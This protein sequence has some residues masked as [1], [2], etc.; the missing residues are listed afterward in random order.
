MTLVTSGRHGSPSSASA[1]LQSSLESRLLPRLDTAGSTLFVETWK[2]KA[3]PLRRRYWEHT[4]SARRTSGSACTSVP[5]PD[6]RSGRGGL[7][8]DPSD[9]SDP[10]R[11][12][13]RGNSMPLESMVL[14]SSVPTP[15]AGPQNDA[16]PDW[17][18]R[19]AEARERHNNGNGFGLNLSM[20]ATLATVTSPTA[21][22]HSRGGQPARPWDTG[23]PLTQQVAL[24]TVA[25]PRNEDSESPGAHRGS[26]DTLPAQTK[27]SAVP[28]PAKADGERGSETMTRG[29]LTLKGAALT[30]VTSPSAR[31][32]K[33]TS[34]M[35]ES[36]VDPDG[37]TRSRLDQL[38]RQAQLAASGPTATGGTGATGSTGQLDPAY[39]RWLMG[40]P[41]AWDA[42]A[43]MAM[44]SSSRS[45]RSSS[46]P[47]AKPSTRS[48]KQKGKA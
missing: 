23:V 47:A 39:S 8:S 43:C 3:T 11:R 26:P 21:R 20:A 27:L 13:E 34:G 40:V 37:S 30:S 41:P 24:A 44:P 22:D 29:N 18:R 46:A 5:S 16:D 38:P 12:I 31:D 33:D 14:M 4:A 42:F 17:E 32:W 1:A 6:A 10:I 9:P 15:N 36:G 48:K 28:T 2:R 35:S 45:R 7:P 25:T 19:R